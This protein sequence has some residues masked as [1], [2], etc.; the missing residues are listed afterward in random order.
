MTRL[1]QLGAVTA[2]LFLFA[3]QGKSAL[4]QNFNYVAAA[5]RM[6]A[7]QNMNMQMRMMS[8]MN[9]MNSMRWNYKDNMFTNN[10]LTF[11]VLFKDS[12]EKEVKSKIYI[13]TV[14]RKTYIIWV[15]KSL[16]KKDPKREQKIY[17]AELK[18]MEIYSGSYEGTY[19][20]NLTTDSC[21]MFK[22]ISGEINVYSNALAIVAIQKHDGPVV[23]FNLSNLQEMV[24]DDP[25]AN[26]FFDK[27][28]YLKA[29]NKYND[30]H[31]KKE[32]DTPAD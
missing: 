10:K 18:G 11:E 28:D 9:M 6:V 4:A 15:D 32:D 17:P 25:K 26:K 24:K 14:S 22:V 7:A 1:S 21:W 16:D 27:K 20:K 12:T 31:E 13:D 2:L 8:N 29:I 30:N 5:G 19:C 3:C 23:P